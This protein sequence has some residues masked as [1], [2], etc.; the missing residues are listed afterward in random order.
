MNKKQNLT[1]KIISDKILLRS[2][3]ES[4]ISEKFFSLKKITFAVIFFCGLFLLSNKAQA[5]ETLI[6][7]NGQPPPLTAHQF[8]CNHAK[9]FTTTQ[10]YYIT[11][12]NAPFIQTNDDR[13]FPDGAGSRVSICLDSNFPNLCK[14]L[15]N[16]IVFSDTLPNTGLSRPSTINY[17]KY[18]FPKTFLPAG[19]YRLV[20]WSL[21]HNSPQENDAR[22]ATFGY[23][24]GSQNVGN[25]FQIFA[26]ITPTAQYITDTNQIAGATVNATIGITTSYILQF[27]PFVLIYIILSLFIVW[28]YRVEKKMIKK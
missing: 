18:T 20:Y 28:A 12:A 22:V 24:N 25:Q 16:N 1:K 27:W 17:F 11:G 4:K 3:G 15:S 10:D 21:S 7:N 8:P 5:V 13:H 19:T 23:E 9:A 6:I 14:V 2:K 26:D